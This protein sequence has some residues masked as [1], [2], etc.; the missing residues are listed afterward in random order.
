MAP[1]LQ[2]MPIIPVNLAIEDELS[3]AVV[4]RLLAH[5]NRN[6]HVGTPY[7]KRGSGY[8]RKN[9]RGWNQAAQGIPLILVTDLDRALCPSALIADW[10]DVPQHPN[11]L[12]RVAVRE[13]EAWLLADGASFARYLRVSPTVVPAS[14]ETELDAKATLIGIARRSPLRAVRERIV[15]RPGSTAQQGPDYNACLS[16]FVAREWNVTTAAVNSRSLSGT[17]RRFELF[18]PKWPDQ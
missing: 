15:P 1:F 11:L 14:P 4:R 9:I 16:E 8:L 10:L 6:F 7:G 12:F 18:E 5:V 17:L 2:Q 3:E 13:I